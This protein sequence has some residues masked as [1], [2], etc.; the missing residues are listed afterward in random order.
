MKGKGGKRNDIITYFIIHYVAISSIINRCCKYWRHGIH[1][2]IW[3]C[4]SM[5]FGNNVANQTPN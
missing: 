1:S 2:V 4:N 3:R 5:H